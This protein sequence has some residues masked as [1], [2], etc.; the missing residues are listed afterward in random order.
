MKDESKCF[1]LPHFLHETN[2]RLLEKPISP[3]LIA[4]MRIS[5]K[6]GISL[7][8]SSF[9]LHPS[10]LR[11]GFTPPVNLLALGRRQPLYVAFRLGR[12]LCFW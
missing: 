2:R 11:A 1:F 12:D 7:H 5:G 10:S 6:K 4:Q 8:P 3:F 9:I